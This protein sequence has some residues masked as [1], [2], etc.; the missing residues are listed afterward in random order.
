MAQAVIGG[1]AHGL[2]HTR[3]LSKDVRLQRLTV[4]AVDHA[5]GDEAPMCGA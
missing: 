1:T 2:S 3:D 5:G 4:L